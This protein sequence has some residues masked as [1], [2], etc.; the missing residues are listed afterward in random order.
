MIQALGP[1]DPIT[2]TRDK[3]KPAQHLANVESAFAYYEVPIGHAAMLEANAFTL[4]IKGQIISQFAASAPLTVVVDLGAAGLKIAESTLV[5][6]AFPTQAHPNAK[7]FIS[8]TGL[9]GSYV[10]TNITAINYVTGQVTVAKT[11][12]TTRVKLYYLL[13]DGEV[14]VRGRKPSA[15]DQ[16][17]RQIFRSSSRRLN[18]IDQVDTKTA[19]KIPT[20]QPLL[21][22]FRLE[23]AARTAGLIVWDDEA[24]HEVIIQAKIQKVLITDREAAERAT[25]ARLGTV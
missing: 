9:P 6:P 14:V 25:L 18:E 24:E 8:D 17:A 11:A 15:Y 4:R 19:P 10:P 13:G 20:P 16:D 3:F 22:Q 1:A 12:T 5:P 23:L 21:S 2:L 7:A